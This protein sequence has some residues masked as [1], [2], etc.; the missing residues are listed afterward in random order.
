MF[1]DLSPAL[2]GAIEGGGAVSDVFCNRHLTN[3]GVHEYMKQK[4]IHYL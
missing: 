1:S 2:V 3:V 4:E